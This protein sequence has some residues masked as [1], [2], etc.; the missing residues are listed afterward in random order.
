[1]IRRALGALFAILAAFAAVVWGEI[2]LAMRREYVPTEPVMEIGGEFGA[3]AHPPLR[4]VVLGD[5]TA[6]GVGTDGPDEA[7]PTL[8]AQRLAASGYHVTL[9]AYGVSGARIT[10][11]LDDQVPRALAADADLVFLGIGAN[12]VIHFTRLDVVRRE[13]EVIIDRLSAGGA[14]LVVAG[15]PDM[16]ALAFHQ[17]LRSL[18][19]FRGQK[20]EAAVAAAAGRRG[21]PV[22]PLAAGAGPFFEAHPEEA[23]SPDDFHP[24][25]GGY[26]RWADV[27]FPVLARALGERAEEASV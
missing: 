23:F 27:I 9:L 6:A 7:Y 18:V 25:A 26:A 14:R 20:V 21:V 24:G 3:S 11:M 10:D 5:S 4:F 15:P 19:G 1:V 2:V 17:P 8:L 13:M 16:R 12:D 22:V